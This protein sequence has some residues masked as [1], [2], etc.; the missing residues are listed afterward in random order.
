MTPG[1][2]DAYDAPTLP[3]THPEGSAEAP[4]QTGPTTAVV[5]ELRGGEVRGTYGVYS[6]GATEEEH[7]RGASQGN[8]KTGRKSMAQ[9]GKNAGRGT[10]KKGLRLVLST[11]LL[12]LL[13][14]MLS[15]LAVGT[16]A[17]QSGGT[18]DWRYKDG[19]A[20]DNQLYYSGWQPAEGTVSQLIALSN[21]HFLEQQVYARN[22]NYQV[23]ANGSVL[24]LGYPVALH[25]QNSCKYYLTGGIDG[26]HLMCESG[27]PR[28]SSSK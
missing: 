27:H 24:A 4:S 10:F 16:S 20:A 19:A 2:A 7:T 25:G 12:V 8:N 14:A 26:G 22:G 13:T 23:M 9:S 18:Y 3:L 15:L 21:V 28:E 11:T 6:G 17:A 5:V 1:Q